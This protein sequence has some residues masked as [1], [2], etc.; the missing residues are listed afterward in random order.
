MEAPEGAQTALVSYPLARLLGSPRLLALA[1]DSST[2]RCSIP[3]SPRALGCASRSLGSPCPARG[4]RDPPC[5][6][7]L[8]SGPPAA[9]KKSQN[10]LEQEALLWPSSGYCPW[11]FSPGGLLADRGFHRA[12]FLAG[13]E[14]HRLEYVVRIK[15]GTAA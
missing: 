1:L 13:L 7:G 3:F 14:R 8:R 15:K 11:G 12:G 2:G 4:G 5:A 9:T 10:Q 6:T